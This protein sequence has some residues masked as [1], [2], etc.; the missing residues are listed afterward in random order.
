MN[1]PENKVALVTGGGSGLG[2]AIALKLQSD[3]MTVAISDVDS[4]VGSATAKESGLFFIEQNVADETRWTEVVAELEARFGALN[5]LVN[6]AGI[7]GTVDSDSPEHC[8]LENWRK[9][10]AVNVE[11]VFLGCR[12]TIPA[13]RRAGG[14]A[15]V[16][17]SSTAALLAL[18]QHVAYSASKAA[19][20]HL[21]KSVAQ[22]CAE[23]GLN[24]TCNSVHPGNVMTSMWK[25][26]IA[27]DRARTHGISVAE[28]IEEA[29]ASSPLNGATTPEDIAAA[30]S[31]LVSDDARRITGTKMIVDGGVINCSTYHS[32][33][34]MEARRILL[35]MQGRP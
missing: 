20:R 33:K 7:V 19:V 29:L 34:H 24:I 6:N 12:A 17:I 30:V 26:T 25:D 35:K 23:E 16:N 5:I 27:V 15:I 8:S 18:P 13:M 3:G 28:A 11:G 22:H 4:T 14:G 31:F 10:F 9:V 21:T 32:R 2:K 1:L